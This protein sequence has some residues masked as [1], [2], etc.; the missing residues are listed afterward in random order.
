M[1]QIINSP[2]RVAKK[3]LKNFI[4]N[5]F[6]LK[7]MPLKL[8]LGNKFQRVFFLKTDLFNKSKEQSLFFQDLFS[9][10][11]IDSFIWEEGYWPSIHN[12][13]TS[14]AGYVPY[15]KLQ[16]TIIMYHFWSINYG[17]RKQILGHIVLLKD[18]KVKKVFKFNLQPGQIR[19]FDLKKLFKGDGDIIFVEVFNPK[20]PKNHGGANGHFRFWGDYS[21]NKSTT[22]SMP[23][24]YIFLDSKIRSCRAT[25]A[26]IDYKDI[27]NKVRSIN[28]YENKTIESK[29]HLLGKINFGYFLQS[30]KT[31]I[32]S[33][34]HS[35]SYSGKL[36]SNTE[37]QFQLVAL[38]P[39]ANI[40]LQL[41]FIEAFT[42]KEKVEITFFI[43]DLRA[44]LVSKKSLR[45]S[46]LDRVLCSEI[47]PDLELGGTQLLIDLS[48]A[49]TP[50]HNGYLHILY[51]CGDML[52]DSVHSH[53]LS[54]PGKLLKSK[55]LI[56]NGYGQSLKFM[57]F[58]RKKSYKSFLSIWT[59]DKKIAAKLRF[60]DN[61]GNEYVKNII[62]N[63]L[64]IV[65]YPLDKILDS[66]KALSEG[67]FVVQLQSNS[68]NLNANLYTYC[69]KYKSLSVDHLT[70]G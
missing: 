33:V 61:S 62:I 26:N 14:I 49:E 16:T 22:H 7:I 5:D 46:H 54:A 56:N 10:T 12:H 18:R 3:I 43:F 42:S 60:I 30:F 47:F 37:D 25:F 29:D 53:R 1:I 57:H 39:V 36:S 20:F 31:S 51:F 23:F 15:I 58:P 9:S 70:G 55:S 27:A 68:A 32:T 65:H 34:W 41:S 48:R 63:P 40:D 11:A 2:L 52:G 38:P 64:G 59:T 67:H 69:K 45:L 35:A 8:I 17:L 13:S 21:S 24:P 28:F 4:A 6:F 50:L 66:L 19:K 44:K